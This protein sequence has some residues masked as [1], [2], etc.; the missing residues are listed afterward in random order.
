MD[1]ETWGLP[2]VI[3]SVGL[4]AGIFLATRTQNTDVAVRP[5]EDH[6]ARREALLEQ[7]RELDADRE[8]MDAGR[9]STRREELIAAA[10][11]ASRA[12][13]QSTAETPAASTAAPI[14]ARVGLW[15][16][17]TLVFFVLLGVLIN[18]YAT[19]RTEGGSMTGN[20]VGGVDMAAISAARSA[21]VEAAQDALSDDPKDLSA[22]NVITYDALL[23]RDLDTAMAHI[24]QAREI[25]PEDTAVLIN[26]AILQMSVGMIDRAQGALD[27]VL[28]RDPSNGRAM[29]WKAFM[30][31]NSGEKDAAIALLE[32]VQ[33]ALE[34]PEETVFAENMLR[35][36]TAPPPV[37]HVSGTVALAEGAEV[38]SGTLYVYA[39]RSEAGGG[40]PVAA[41]Q[42]RAGL[43]T[44]F[45][46]T[47]AD[48][49]MG[50][51]WP[52]QVW[53]QARLDA[54]GD[55][56]TREDTLAES[57]VIGPIASGAEALALTLSPV[58]AAPQAAPAEAAP[59][60][61]EV[62]AP[63]A[64]A[65][66]ASLRLSGEIALF[67]A[68]PPGAVV[69]AIVRRAAT[70]GGPPVAAKRLE[71]TSEALS[72]TFTDADM[73]MGGTWP[74]EVYLSARLDLDANAMTRDEGDIE[75]TVVG[76]LSSGTSGI[77]L[78]LNASGALAE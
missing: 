4:S 37:T 43:P 2:L 7:I 66:A 47:D 74:D 64:D 76:P 75:S 65:E 1:W 27:G 16:G 33:G 6:A 77:T 46:L 73:M 54:D 72:F 12:L 71:P 78:L 61:S 49:V 26:L 60:P 44:A 69:F 30:L 9:Y 28:A 67:R 38:G 22:L 63:V 51:V 70:G 20:S 48:M 23:Y 34:W 42:H 10:A 53:V 35:E 31:A 68:A 58:D 45:T 8:K 32:G 62:P 3:L 24:D 18:Q 19:P 36:L 15:G 40:P 50:G 25:D 29:M 5:E 57:V 11:A 41:F 13:E 39:R 55:P 59:A 17:I 14:S 21:R 56:M 52:E